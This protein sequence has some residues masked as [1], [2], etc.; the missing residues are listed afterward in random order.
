MRFP[1]SFGPIFG[2]HGCD[3]S[4]A[5]S[6]LLQGKSLKA[7]TNDYDWLGEGIY[8]WVDSPERARKWAVDRKFKKPAVIGAVIYPGFCLN[9]TDSSIAP[10]I[11]TAFERYEAISNTA[12][13]PLAQNSPTRHG[14]VLVRRLDRAVIQTL[15]QIRS[16][17]GDAPYDTVL[18][19]FEEGEP[20]YP[21]AA[22]KEYNHIQIAVRKPA[23][24]IGYFKP[25]D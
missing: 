12:Q 19:A 25:S 16:D 6:V 20:I 18:G 8:F 7:S 15:H 9:L 4:V 5:D 17:S 13:T 23:A 21:G 24:I 10:E 3:K 2:Y 22:L 1:N 14:T 11:R